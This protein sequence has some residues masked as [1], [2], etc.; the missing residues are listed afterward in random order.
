[1][2]QAGVGE[3]VI[4]KNKRPIGIVT[5]RDLALAMANKGIAITERVHNVM[6][7]PVDTL[8]SSDGV[9]DATRRMM[10]L[11]VR[12]L[13]VVSPRGTLVGLN[14]EELLLLLVHQLSHTSEGIKLRL[15]RGD[16]RAS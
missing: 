12:R 14:L 2:K 8:T 9:Y 16:V 5:D 3:V 11:Q 4:A 15:S 10:E 7:C 1:M 13:P 6:T